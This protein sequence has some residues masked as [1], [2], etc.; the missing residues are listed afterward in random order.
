[1]FDAHQQSHSPLIYPSDQFDSPK[2]LVDFLG[3]M[4]HSSKLIVLPDG[5]VL[6]TGSGTE[7]KDI[8]STIA[9]FYLSRNSTTWR[10]QSMLVP[11]VSRLDTSKVDANITG[12]S[13][14]V[15][16]VTAAALKRYNP[17]C[18]S[19]MTSQHEVAHSESLCPDFCYLELYCFLSTISLAFEGLKY[20]GMD[21]EC[22]WEGFRW[23]K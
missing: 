15:R 17:F 14:K 20:L 1:M 11:H 3:D 7:M 21:W 6:L 13:S 19:L 22:F 9:E 18:Q 5:R 16:D 2:S 8:L 10:K 23:V 12:S 4:A